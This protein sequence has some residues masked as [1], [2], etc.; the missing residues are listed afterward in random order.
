MMCTLQ[1]LTKTCVFGSNVVQ[2][3]ESENTNSSEIQSGLSQLVQ[4]QG[5]GESVPVL[6]QKNKVSKTRAVDKMQK[7]CLIKSKN[8][9]YLDFSG[10]F[11]HAMYIIQ[12]LTYLRQREELITT[13]NLS[14]HLLFPYSGGYHRRWSVCCCGNC[15]FLR[16][17]LCC[18]FLLL[19]GHKL[20]VH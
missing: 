13:T 16:C 7:W 15:C 19:L 10:T 8:R 14:L 5:E 3:L 12:Y 18:F 9:K 2:L 17:F 6:V 11:V 1:K 4:I 20:S